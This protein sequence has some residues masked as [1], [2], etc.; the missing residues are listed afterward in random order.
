MNRQRME[1]ASQRQHCR[2]HHN[3]PEPHRIVQS[4]AT[5]TPN[6][7][8]RRVGDTATHSRIGCSRHGS[9]SMLIGEVDPRGLIPARN[10]D[11][12][13]DVVAVVARQVDEVAIGD[14]PRDRHWIELKAASADV[15]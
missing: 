8:L 13:P 14:G 2:E 12:D 10:R 9:P 11:G 6:L 4:L 1:Q 5:A 3:D 15:T 7:C